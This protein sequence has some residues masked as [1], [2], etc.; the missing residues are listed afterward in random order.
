MRTVGLIVEY[1]P[2]HNGHYYHL[3]QSAKITKADAVVAVMSGNFL[4]RGEPALLDK[5]TRT[6]MALRGGCDLVIEL[7]VA[8]STQAAEWF[9]Y[10]AVALLGA[11]GVVDALCFGSEAGEIGPLRRIA[12]MLAHEPEPFARLMADTLG[13]GASYPAAY[14]E[15]VRLYMAQ[16]GDHEAAAFPLE[17]PNNTLGLHYLLALERLGSRIEPHTIRREKAGYSQSDITDGEIA[18][19][20]AIRRLVAQQGAPDDAAPY[21]PRAT[22]DLLQ[23]DY[24]AGRGPVSWSS[25]ARP[26]FHKLMC[27]SAGSLADYHEM[28][29]GLQHRLKRSVSTLSSLEVEPLLE[30]LKTRRYT[31]TKLQRMLLAVLLGHRKADLSPDRLQSGIQYIRVLG[32]TGKGRELLKKMKT[33]ASLPILHS[34]ARPPEPYPYLELDVQATAAYTL[35][36]TNTSAR[37]CFRDYYQKPIVLA[38][39]TF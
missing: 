16:A 30:A 4:Q 37:D 31:R 35:A 32:F 19:A 1:N 10:G 25:F 9:A 17:Q 20:T 33:T 29:E 26:L 2:F 23:R 21:V 27:E 34:A 15:A 28:S 38:E 11:T 8:Y 24:A 22:M 7:P 5:W 39:G 13:R 18:S 14:S 6:E 36:R 3:Q 12:R